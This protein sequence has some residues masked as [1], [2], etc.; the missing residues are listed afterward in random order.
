MLILET[1]NLSQ[2]FGKG[3]LIL[4]N[5]NFKLHRGEL[6]VLAGAN[7]SG[8][9]VFARHLN[10]LLQ[11]SSGRVLLEGVP[12]NSNLAEARRKVGFVF[13]NS[14]NQIVG[15]TVAGDVAFG[16]ENL[17]LTPAEVKKRVATALAAVE[18][19]EAADYRPYRL[20]GGQK[21]KLAIAGVLAMQPQVIILDEPFTGLDYPGVVQV[22]N[23]LI[24]L[25]Q[26]GYALLVIT[27]ELEKVLAHADRM[28]IMHLGR[29]VADARPETLLDRIE[30]YGIKKPYGLHRSVETMTWLN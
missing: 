25:R 30:S 4:D 22:L 14:D 19:T 10:G 17:G 18:L 2:N 16:P 21:R 13:Q 8:K 23:Q 28:V 5:I 7:G 24:R 9:T 3:S 27:H 20:S 12:I 11:P 15:E 26:A 29:I 6:V 1:Q